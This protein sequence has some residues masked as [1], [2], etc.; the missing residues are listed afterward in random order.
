[1]SADLKVAGLELDE[2]EGQSDELD[3]HALI[4]A[5][6]RFVGELVYMHFPAELPPDFDLVQ[7]GN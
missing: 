6:D 5:P 2:S 7:I 3:V 4:D 1:M